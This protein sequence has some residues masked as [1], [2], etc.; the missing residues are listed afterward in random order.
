MGRDQTSGKHR[1]GSEE[2]YPHRM[3][4]HARVGA[5]YTRTDLRAE[6]GGLAAAPGRTKGVG[7]RDRRAMGREPQGREERQGQK[8]HREMVRKVIEKWT[9]A[10]DETM[11]V[12]NQDGGPRLLGPPI[13]WSSWRFILSP[14]ASLER[15]T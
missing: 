13:P 8:S 6:A 2:R 12:A 3:H 11:H 14:A 7:G 1:R 10:E 5:L 15:A 9:G 4:V